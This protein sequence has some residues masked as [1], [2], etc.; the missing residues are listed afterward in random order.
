MLTTDSKPTDNSC[1]PARTDQ[2]VYNYFNLLKFFKPKSRLPGLSLTNNNINYHSLIC[3]I[4]CYNAEQDVT[5]HLLVNN[6]CATQ[7][8]T[9]QDMAVIYIFS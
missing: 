6:Q 4:L 1:A 8:A 5:I 3:I 9:T 7:E 2:T